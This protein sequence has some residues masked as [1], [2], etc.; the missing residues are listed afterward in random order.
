MSSPLSHIRVLDL[1]RVLAGPWATQFLADM[2]AEVIKVERPGEGDD[3]RAWGPPFLV[4]PETE[5]GEAGLSAYFACTNRGKRSVAIDIASKEGQALIRELARRS[6]VVVENFKV[7]GLAQYG[8]DYE[9]LN[10]IN[11]RI[12]Y[13]S[14]TGFGQTGP[15]AQR[16]GYDYLVQGMAG[17][18]SI[19]GKPDDEP[20]GGPIKVGV[21]VS[22]VC[23]GWNAVGAILSALLQRERTGKGAHIDVA[24]F[25]VTLALLINQASSFLATGQ[26]PQRLGNSH[27]SLTPY[28]AFQTAD[29]NMILAIGNNGQF[30]RFYETA[31]LPDVAADPRFATNALRIA[32][33]SALMGL[34]RPQ[35]AKR[36]TAQWVALLEPQAVPCGPVNTIADAINEPQCAA[37]ELVKTLEHPAIG[38]LQVIGN[39]V[40]MSDCATTATKAPPLLG[41]DTTDV[42]SRV[43]GLGS[44]DIERLLT[45][46]VIGCRRG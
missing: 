2:G 14:I 44:A 38:P 33:R 30:Q 26:T 37:R 45:Q 32:N 40:K 28:D 15:N 41:E 42:L 39:A 25:D 16:A 12:V 7:G 34:L 24:L 17:L 31:G 43:L 4:P 8:L 22:D 10:K 18:M 5:A 13:C 46:G 23:A 6:D 3:T 35:L 19:T 11:P 20:G 27:P 29:G 21:A 9:S 1:S 36:T